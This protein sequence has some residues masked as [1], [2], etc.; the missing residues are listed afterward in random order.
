MTEKPRDHV[1]QF[2]LAVTQHSTRPGS[3]AWQVSRSLWTG[4]RPTQSAILLS[5]EL[6]VAFLPGTTHEVAYEALS[7][8]LDQYLILALDSAALP[9]PPSSSEAPA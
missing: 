6:S 5:G 7:A 1:R 9:E 2:F 8:A 3:V 4:G